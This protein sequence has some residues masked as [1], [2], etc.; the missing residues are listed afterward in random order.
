MAYS[1]IVSRKEITWFVVI[2]TGILEGCIV[3]YNQLSG[4]TTYVGFL[5]VAVSFLVGWLFAAAIGILLVLS[6]LHV[7]LFLNK[8]FP[9]TGQLLKRA[10]LEASFSILLAC[11]VGCVITLVS[12]YFFP[13]HD[14]L[15][16]NLVNNALITVV[17]NLLVMS[18]LEA[19]IHYRE[20]KESCRQA[21]AL[22]S[23]LTS[24]RFEVLKNQINPHFMFNSLSVL[25]GLVKTNP[26]LA[27]TFISDFAS[28][29]RYVL[30]CIDKPVVRLK[31]ELGFAQAYMHLQT[32][33]HGESALL[34]AVEVSAEH[35]VYGLP[36]LS[37]QIVLENALKHNL[38]HAESPLTI[39]IWVEEERLCV[40]NNLQVRQSNTPSTKVGLVN[41]L[42]RYSILH[43]ETPQFVVKE[44]DYL[45]RLPLIQI[46]E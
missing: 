1:N 46:D 33:R 36:P 5:S 21:V 35:L 44:T 41:L 31:E 34:Y 17:V 13:Y 9:W 15:Q 10:V 25:S 12:H 11:L 43:T 37:L 7:I 6:D 29:Y 27:Q 23:E 28:V 24:I 45:V 8:R 30:D 20:F 22:E 3:G 42:K 32:I 16:V 14:G 19:W 4:K 26:L 2:L 18:I 40:S 38:V 39:R